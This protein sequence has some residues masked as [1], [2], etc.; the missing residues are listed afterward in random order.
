MARLRKAAPSPEDAENF[1]HP[2]ADLSARPKIETPAHFKKRIPPTTYR[3]DSSLSIALDWDGENPACETTEAWIQELKECG[4]L[5]AEL[6]RQPE[7][8]ERDGLLAELT[9]RFTEAR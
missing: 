7:T 1:R 2:T 5:A 8:K 6:A 9:S 4:L 3:Y